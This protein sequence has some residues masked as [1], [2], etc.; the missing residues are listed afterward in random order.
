M[1]ALR[2]I[3]TAAILSSAAFSGHSTGVSAGIVIALFSAK[4]AFAADWQ[5][6]HDYG[7]ARQW[8]DYDSL[9]VLNDMLTM[10]KMTWVKE[11]A[12]T[13]HTQDTY[14][15]RDGSKIES[16]PLFFMLEEEKNWRPVT[17]DMKSIYQKGLR[18][19]GES[20]SV[21]TSAAWKAICGAMVSK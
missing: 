6:E 18:L 10:E 7:F 14:S 2:K 12:M 9:F 17:A 20:S 3:L 13:F 4:S 8:I 11:A 15:C 19:S 16:K 21:A 1:R 5:I